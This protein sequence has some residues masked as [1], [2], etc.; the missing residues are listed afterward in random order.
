MPVN[1]IFFIEIEV[2][3]HFLSAIGTVIKQ[4]LLR[5]TFYTARIFSEQNT[6]IRSRNQNAKWFLDLIKRQN[7][8]IFYFLVIMLIL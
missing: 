4:A 7:K 3:V 8:R 1:Q 6:K 5:M 2:Q